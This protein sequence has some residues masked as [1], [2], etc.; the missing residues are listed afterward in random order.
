MKKHLILLSVLSAAGLIACDKNTIFEKPDSPAERTE[1]N[2]NISGTTKITDVTDE[3]TVKTLQ[4]LV[5]RE[6]NTLDAYATASNTKT[7]SISCTTGERTV[8]AFANAPSLSAIQNLEALKATVSSLSDN[9]KGALIMFGSK[10]TTVPTTADVSIEVVRIVSRFFLKT[11]KT[12]FASKA[13]QNMTFT[14][15]K[16]YLINVA[17]NT[18]YAAAQPTEWINK[19]KNENSTSAL[20]CDE[21]NKTIA[22]G[23]T[24]GDNHYLYAYPNPT[25]PDNFADT[26]S[27]RMTRFVI[28]TTLGS[29]TYY[30]PITIAETLSNKSYEIN[31]TIKHPGSLDPDEPISSKEF[32]VVIDVKDW[33]TV[34]VTETI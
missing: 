34:P 26:W 2:V 21:V 13:Y 4:V 11:L 18:S 27:P 12:D 32:N 9:D 22:N 33:T 3:E 10:G 7:L 28:E 24:L 1:L 8:Y 30:Y 5:F 15:K 20:V 31:L 14:V 19:M 16:V 6:D 25:T 29:T 23:G 17:A